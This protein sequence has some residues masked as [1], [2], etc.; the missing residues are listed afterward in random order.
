MWQNFSVKPTG[1]KAW[2]GIGIPVWVLGGLVL[3]QVLA[4]LLLALLN[5]LGV[6]FSGVNESVLNTTIA[7]VIYVFTL[8]LVVGL[9]WWV[10]K[11]RT[12]AK[13]L[14]LAEF[15]KFSDF[16]WAPIGFFAY[17]ILSYI[18][19]L[20][21]MAT[22]FY[23]KTSVQDVGFT[24]LTHNYEYILAF[25]TL[26][27]IAPVAEEVLF[28]GYL[29]GKLRK[30]VSLIVSILITSLLFAIVHLNFNVGV[31]VF[32]LSIILC[33]LRIKTDSLWPAIFLHMIKNGLAFYFLFINPLLFPTLGG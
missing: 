1:G 18:L 3:A 20:I 15:P 27:V 32:A 25:L 23:D 10:K 30:N 4:G 7:A 6:K 19:T 8:L 13:E 16:L 2:K 21:G 24:N 11:Y 28:R 33:L 22:P 31:D 26:V 12:T 17:M 29:L 14:G 9:P 5:I